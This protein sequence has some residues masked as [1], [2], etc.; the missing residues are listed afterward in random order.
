MALQ[1]WIE[2]MDPET[3]RKVDVL[4]GFHSDWTKVEPSLDVRVKLD[5]VTRG[6]VRALTGVEGAPVFELSDLAWAVDQ[7]EGVDA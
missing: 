5:A 6:V 4:V 3:G 2:V 1:A 7:E